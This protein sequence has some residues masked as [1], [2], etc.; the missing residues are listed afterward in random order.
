MLP[1]Q[2]GPQG[3]FLEE[4]KCRSPRQNWRQDEVCASSNLDPRNVLRD[5]MH[6]RKDGKSRRASFGVARRSQ[7]TSVHQSE[8]LKIES[9][10]KDTICTSAIH[11]RSAPIAMGTV[12]EHLGT[13]TVMNNCTR[14]VALMLHSRPSSVL[15]PYLLM[16]VFYQEFN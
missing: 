2:R 6:S 1:T 15:V 4:K 3:S 14:L 5:V 8:S 10:K 7:R 12:I 11:V 16:A 9:T 13:R